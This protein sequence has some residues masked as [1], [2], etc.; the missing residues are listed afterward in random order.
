MLRS[1]AASVDAV[2][3]WERESGCDQTEKKGPRRLRKL[4]RSTYGLMAS[5]ILRPCSAADSGHEEGRALD[6][7]VNARDPEQKEMA[8]AFLGWLQA[9]DEYGNPSVMARRLGIQ[10]VIFNNQMWQPSSSSWSAYSSC[11]KR[12]MRKMRKKAYDNACHRNHVHV[13]FSWDGAL[14][15]TSFYTGYVACPPPAADLWA[16]PVTAPGEPV[17]ISPVAALRTKSGVGLAAAACKVNPG[18]RIDLPVTG[19]GAVPL[20][21]TTAVTLSVRVRAADAPTELRVWQAG[22]EAPLAAALVVAKGQP[23]AVTVAVPVG[24]EGLVSLQL[25]GG[26]AHIAVDVVGAAVAAPPPPVLPAT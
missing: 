17:T 7:M 4:L 8:D 21:G 20:T 2:A 24:V 3:T 18:V 19:L 5:N 26:M 22:T 6:W 23:G 15:R 16:L 9:P 11:A 14:G 10:Y 1:P 25:T 13:S 12:K